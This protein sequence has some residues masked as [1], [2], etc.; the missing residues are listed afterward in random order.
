MKKFLERLKTAENLYTDLPTNTQAEQK[1][2][3]L[4]EFFSTREGRR[5][6]YSDKTE[7][8]ARIVTIEKALDT[9]VVTRYNHYGMDY[10]G[11]TTCCIQYS[12][13]LCGDAK[14]EIENE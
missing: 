1:N 2:R 7:K 10:S 6:L 11:K 4:K 5:A 13:I 12:S 8:E 3:Q 14:V 9:F